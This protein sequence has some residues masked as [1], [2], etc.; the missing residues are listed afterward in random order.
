VD[1]KRWRSLVGS[2]Q[3][4]GAGARRV[5]LMLPQTYVNLSGRAVG[6]AVRDTSVLPGQVWIV[7]DELDLPLC[8][9]RIRLGGSAAGHN[10]LRSIIGALGTEDFVRF[11]IG[12]GKP[13]SAAAGARFVLGRFSSREEPLVGPLVEGVTEAVELALRSG[14]EAAMGAYNRAGALGCE[15]AG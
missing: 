9:L 13:P 10:G 3:L 2:G 5:W 11:R 8:R 4:P 15:E 1:R 7:H 14:L 6:A 12:V